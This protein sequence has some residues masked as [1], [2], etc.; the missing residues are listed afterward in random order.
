[1]RSS[2]Q[3]RDRGP[4]AK[5]I[6]HQSRSVIMTKVFLVRKPECV[7]LTVFEVAISD[8]RL[9]HVGFFILSLRGAGEVPGRFGV[10][11]AI[12]FSCGSISKNN[13]QRSRSF[14]AQS[15]HPVYVRNLPR[16]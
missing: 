7:S 15:F 10:H 3:D 5:P 14:T 1:M 9:A 6:N 13:S 2:A 12:R 11:G 8:D 16:T 4:C